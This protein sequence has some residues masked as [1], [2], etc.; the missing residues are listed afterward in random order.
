MSKS[1]IQPHGGTLINR[2]LS[3]SERE[4]GLAKA[5]TLTTLTLSDR[6]LSDL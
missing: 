4:Q 1:L 2:F 6:S 3:G 5:K